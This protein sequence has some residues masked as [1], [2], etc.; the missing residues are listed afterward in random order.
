MQRWRVHVQHDVSKVPRP[1]IEEQIA[2]ASCRFP[3]P[4]VGRQAKQTSG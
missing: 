4:I 3:R 2:Q 1:I